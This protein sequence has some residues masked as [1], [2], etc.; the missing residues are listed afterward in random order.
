M[1]KYDVTS[2]SGEVFVVTA[3]EGTSKKDALR[4]AQNQF[5][6]AQVADPMQSVLPTSLTQSFIPTTSNV[7]RGFLDAAGSA[8]GRSIDRAKIGLGDTLPA[9]AGSALGFDDYA[10]KQIKEGERA[11]RNLNLTNPTEVKTFRD[12]EIGNALTYGTESVFEQVANL[13]IAIGSATAGG[14]LFSLAAKRAFKKKLAERTKNLSRGKA[15]LSNE[16]IKTAQG[17][18]NADLALAQANATT[19][20]INYGAFFGSFALNAPE[21]FSNVYEATG[22]MSPVAAVLAGS[23][24]AALDSILPRAIV[25][26]LRRNP[27]LKK[28]VVGNALLQKGVSKDALAAAGYLAPSVLRSAGVGAGKGLALEGVTEA[29]QEAISIA[30]ERIVGD[31]FQALNSQEYDRLIESGLRGAIAGGAFGGVGGVNKGIGE[32]SIDRKV[33]KAIADAK[34]TQGTSATDVETLVDAEKAKLETDDAS[35]PAAPAAPAAPVAP[36]IPEVELTPEQLQPFVESTKEEETRLEEINARVAEINQKQQTEGVSL[37]EQTER[38]ILQQEIADIQT[39]VTTRAR[40]GYNAALEAIRE[41]IRKRIADIEGYLDGTEAAPAPEIVAELEELQ[42]ELAGVTPE[43]APE[44]APEVV[45]VAKKKKPVVKKPK[46]VPKAVPEIVLDVESEI[47]LEPVDLEL[48][49]ENAETAEEK[50]ILDEN[51]ETA[52][53][54]QELDFETQKEKDKDPLPKI[55]AAQNE[56]ESFEWLR[57]R[58]SLQQKV[59]K[60]NN[61]IIKQRQVL[62]P[63]IDINDESAGA[64]INDERFT[65]LTNALITAEKNLAAHNNNAPEPIRDK[66]GTVLQGLHLES[67][68]EGNAGTWRYTSLKT[69]LTYTQTLK[70]TVEKVQNVIKARFGLFSFDETSPVAVYTNMQEYIDTLSKKYAEDSVRILAQLEKDPSKLTAMELLFL[71][72]VETEL[73]PDPGNTLDIGKTKPTEAQF[74]EFLTKLTKFREGMVQLGF[75]QSGYISFAGINQS[76]LFADHIPEGMELVVFMHEVGVHLGLQGLFSTDT[77]AYGRLNNQLVSG[78][79]NFAAE[80]VK[81]KENESKESFESRKIAYK[82]ATQAIDTVEK[83]YGKKYFNTEV[84]SHFVH[85]AIEEGYTPSE[86]AAEKGTALGKWFAKFI[87]YIEKQFDKII[88]QTTTSTLKKGQSASKLELSVQEIVNLSFGAASAVMQL[89]ANRKIENFEQAGA[90]SVTP[91]NARTIL[92]LT[93][94]AYKPRKGKEPYEP[95]SIS[96]NLNSFRVITEVS[97]IAKS[98]EPLFSLASKAKETAGKTFGAADK[99]IDRNKGLSNI[100]DGLPRSW[101]EVSPFLQDVFYNVMSFWQ[102]SDLVKSFNPVLAQR[103]RDLDAIVKNRAYEVATAREEVQKLVTEKRDLLKEVKEKV[104]VVEYAKLL[105]KMNDFAMDATLMQFDFRRT[106]FLKSSTVIE[107]SAVPNDLTHRD[108][109]K[110]YEALPDQ[111]KKVLTDIANENEAMREKYILI[112][113]RYV[114]ENQDAQGRSVLSAEQRKEF[115]AGM[116]DIQPYFTLARTGG[117]WIRYPNKNFNPNEPESTTNRP[118][119]KRSFDGPIKRN[120]VI[121]EIIRNKE[122]N[123]EDI[124]KYAPSRGSGDEAQAS[125]RI[126]QSAIAKIKATRENE[127]NAGLASLTQELEKDFLA[128]FPASSTL[129][130]WKERKGDPGFNANVMEDYAAMHQKQASEFALFESAEELN[131]A[132]DLI[133]RTDTSG[134][135]KIELINELKRLERDPSATGAQKQRLLS[136]IESFETNTRVVNEIK[137]RES[138][139]H[140]P[141]AGKLPRAFSYFGYFYLI[142]GNISSAIIQLTQA[143]LVAQGILGGDYT[144]DD[145]FKALKDAFVYYNKNSGKDDNTTLRIFSGDLLPVGV[146]GFGGKQGFELSDVSMFAPRKGK[147]TPEMEKLYEASLRTASVRRSTAQEAIDLQTGSNKWGTRAFIKANLAGGWLFQNTERANKEITLLAAYNLSKK[148]YPSLNIDQ[149]IARAVDHV[150]QINGPALNEVGPRVFQ[151]GPGKAIG[152]FKKFAFSQIY[153]QAKLA[154]E[155][156]GKV[157]DDMTRKDVEEEVGRLTKFILEN[158]NDNKNPDY[159]SRIDTLNR[160]P[161]RPEGAPST[162]QIALRQIFMTSITSFVFAGLRGLPFYGAVTMFYDI[163]SDMLGDDDETLDNMDTIIQRAFT[164]LGHGGVLSALLNIDLASRTGFYGY[165]YRDDPYRR[166]QVGD[167]AYLLESFL[168]PTGLIYRNVD[169]ALDLREQGQTARAIETMLPSFVKNPLK[170]IRY[171]MEGVLTKNGTPIIEDPSLYNELMQFVGFSNYELARQYRKNEL[172]SRQERNITK[173]ASK[174]KRLYFYAVYEGDNDEAKKVLEDINKFNKQKIVRNTGYGISNFK[175]TQSVAQ[176]R[177]RMAETID[178]LYMNPNARPAIEEDLYGFYDD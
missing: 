26:Q 121:G 60:A 53:D 30:A 165:M 73:N 70:T 56:I 155:A 57:N 141:V 51:A 41:P 175:L 150:E 34:E 120:R 7:D 31:N 172:M 159:Q 144:Y 127:D 171:N 125:S 161:V 115:L 47:D 154:R 113:G 178:G 136:Q 135:A 21:V 123:K 84:L 28:A 163:V 14:K 112:M 54:Q 48:V 67:P 72:D 16:A 65:P 12:V 174:L 5:T 140:A 107:G 152:T 10:K 88:S 169:K 37:E 103:I 118:T 55:Q 15:P 20:G 81:Q 74:K 108:M 40:D 147:N 52:K 170:A 100:V 62:V 22:D 75:A 157:P 9:L 128:L 49:D 117:Y 86:L 168:G 164:D 177:R 95:A 29:A 68:G 23:A 24:A 110:R 11:R 116:P 160:I 91:N 89:G 126:L 78:I 3:P 148:F 61:D 38:N 176:R 146:K 142:M 93:G 8:V 133:V 167:F 50:K 156:L 58:D 39:N 124:I 129:K 90:F 19:R 83:N 111:M 122:A 85:L 63:N 96:K 35:T 99:I 18:I 79:R 137:Q 44:V 153:L 66:D 1:P 80:P 101:A 102:M 32:K 145:A 109:V 158:P 130:Q 132:V 138:F 6:G 134:E 46:A 173:K 162:K 149:H 166:E 27:A 33:K 13:G 114:G 59:D 139:L 104:S 97:D 69:S 105:D 151:Q 106:D 17:K 2:P 143:P 82:L 42:A 71:Q 92:D 36:P 76:V 45:P 119:T 94:P 77:A 98:N 64:Y 43:V 25:K 87:N 131:N 4:Y